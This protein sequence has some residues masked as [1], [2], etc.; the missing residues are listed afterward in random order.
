METNTINERRSYQKYFTLNKR[1]VLCLKDNAPEDL[2]VLVYNIHHSFDALPN[3]W[4]YMQ[5][6]NAFEAFSPEDYCLD[7]ITIETDCAYG[8]LYR[9]AGESFAHTCMSD[10]L[11]QA[12]KV[13]GFYELIGAGQWLAMD[14]IY[15]MVSDFI[16][17]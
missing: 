14:R 11:E 8:D 2:K 7:D 3:D 17:E 15:H 13:K 4:I 5:I 6:A 9:W 1:E 16:N 10:Y 12:G